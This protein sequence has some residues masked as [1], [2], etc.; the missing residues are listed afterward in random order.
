[1]Q[2]IRE[3]LQ[4]RQTGILDDL[5]SIKSAVMLPLMEHQGKLSIVFEIRSYELNHQPGE[6]CF[7]GGHQ[8]AKD[9]GPQATAIRETSEELGINPTEITILGDL[10]VLVTPFRFILYPFVGFINKNVILK[11]QQEE[12]AE[13]FFVPL[14]YLLRAEPTISY[15]NVQMSPVPDFPLHLLP[16][17]KDY[18]WRDGSYPVYFYTYDKYIIWGLTAR[19]LYHFLQL[20][21][22]EFE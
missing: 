2:Q 1:M 12:V 7:P 5:N 17:G 21:K 16:N 8:E 10:D 4:D 13:V 18:N 22:D 19:I 9:E 3:I 14:N 15:T 6:I 11:P 20:I